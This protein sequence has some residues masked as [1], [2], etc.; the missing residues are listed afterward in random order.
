MNR[1]TNPTAAS[2]D[3]ERDLGFGSVVARESR[4]RLLN[5]DGTFNVAR[6][7]LSPLSSFNLYHAMLTITWGKFMAIVVFSYLVTNVLFALAY[8]ACGPGA[9][10]VPDGLR[11]ENPFWQ[12]FF[13][14]VHTLGTIGYG[15]ITPAGMAANLIVTLE[16]LFGLLGFALVTGLL[17]SRFSRP[18]AKILFSQNAIIAPYREMTA[19]EFRITNARR[20]Q[21]IEL[22]ATV[23]YTQFENHDGTPMRRFYPLKLERDRVTFFSLSWTI[24]H[25]IDE[26][27]PLYGK[28]EQDLD[29]ANAEIL[30]LLT[31]IDETFSQTV[32]TRSSYKADE[33]VWHARFDNI[34]NPPSPSG[35]L[36]IDV[37]KL[38]SIEQLETR[39]GSER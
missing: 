36:T 30:I 37:Q 10:S 25:P 16:A 2:R 12:A 21:I 7:G 11:V 1:Q 18:T 35:R 32:H 28:T 9:L 23:M 24:V 3:E 8:L 13:F 31:G 26:K 4:K 6:K 20:N 33:I 29:A 38:G 22:N 19:F 34:Y 39:S 17:F 27:S 15:N 14:S 5:R